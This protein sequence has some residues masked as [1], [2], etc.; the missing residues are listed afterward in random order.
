MDLQMIGKKI[1]S[2]EEQIRKD[3]AEI[4]RITSQ[5][6]RNQERK[7]FLEGRI[8]ENNQ[9]LSNL[10]N[11]KAMMAIEGSIGKIDD[12]KLALLV[13][14]LEEHG[15]KIGKEKDEEPEAG[16]KTE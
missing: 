2:M 1:Q 12:D 3:E 8:R 6:K 14:I 5:I 9:E 16:A 10:N 7:R 15:D 11:R 13:K 4:E